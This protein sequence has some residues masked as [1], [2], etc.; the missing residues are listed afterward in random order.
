M[1]TTLDKIKTQNFPTLNFKL[2]KIVHL[3]DNKNIKWLIL[4]SKLNK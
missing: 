3:N 2:V 4:Y 1:T